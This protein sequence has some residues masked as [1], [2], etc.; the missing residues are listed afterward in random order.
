[1]FTGLIRHQATVRQLKT[2]ESG[3]LLQL[4]YKNQPID[5]VGVGDSIAVNGCCLTVLAPDEQGF[6]A[7]LSPETIAC[8]TFAQCQPGDT[9][10]LEPSM[11][12]GEALDGHL[13]TGHVDV[14][15]QLRQREAV[16]SDDADGVILWFDAPESLLPLIAPKGS[17]CIDGISLTVNAVD[18]HGFKVQIIPHTLA[19]TTLGMLAVGS[20][21]NL[22]ADLLARYVARLQGYPEKS[23]MHQPG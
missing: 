8:T 21:V 16:S 10:N 6:S 13:V 12:L 3:A 23:G 9:V 18:R 14:V 1:M 7:D 17:I 2:T 20:A 5:N 4:D 22:E 15:G 19:V 11:R